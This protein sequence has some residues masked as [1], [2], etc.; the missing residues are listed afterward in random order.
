M[1]T[2]RQSRTISHLAHAPFDRVNS[3]QNSS[4]ILNTKVQ[5]YEQGT[6]FYNKY[7]VSN[8]RRQSCELLILIHTEASSN[9][10]PL[11]E[12]FVTKE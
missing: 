2:N 10:V 8:P 6:R 4:L 7:N 1:S 3:V 12:I 11:Y 9:T 5:N